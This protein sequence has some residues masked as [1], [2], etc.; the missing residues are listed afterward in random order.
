MESR[1]WRHRL[2]WLVAVLF[3]AAACSS[4]ESQS[5]PRPDVTSGGT[6]S[7]SGEALPA[8]SHGAFCREYEKQ[9]RLVYTVVSRRTASGKDL[10]ITLTVHNGSERHLLGDIGGAMAVT[11]RGPGSPPLYEWGDSP[12][13]VVG[14]H[15]LTTR[16]V[17]ISNL[18]TKPQ[19][20]PADAKVSV[21]GVWSRLGPSRTGREPCS[22]PADVR[23]PRG[24]VI[25]HPDGR[26]SLSA[27]RGQQLAE[28]AQR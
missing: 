10:T 2:A 20:V 26:W 22:L 13:D 25:G 28:Q 8:L 9:V 27:R 18:G 4:G 12:N 19:P 5:E 15:A 6:T 16:R 24:L 7:P 11:M 23:A 21:L 14:V 1:R 17:L 3:L